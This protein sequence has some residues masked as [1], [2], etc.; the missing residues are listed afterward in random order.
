MCRSWVG[1]RPQVPL[2]SKPDGR[3]NVEAAGVGNLG[4]LGGIGSGGGELDVEV[5][6]EADGRGLVVLLV[7]GDCWMAENIAISLFVRNSLWL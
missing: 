3:T 4:D 1:H 6:P 7:V 5:I 2:I